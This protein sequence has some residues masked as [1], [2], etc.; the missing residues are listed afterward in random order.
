MEEV[1]YAYNYCIR[2]LSKRDYSVYKIKR[3]LNERKYDIDVIESVVEKLLEQNYLREDEFKR[4]KIKQHLYKG[5]SNSYIQNKLSSTEKLTCT[6]EEI[7][8]LRE[9]MG[10]TS[11]D[12]INGLIDKKLRGNKSP[13]SFE[14]KMKL[15]KKLMSF[16]ISKGHSY[17]QI[18]TPVEE[19]LSILN[20]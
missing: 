17:D 18:C 20:Q 4:Q 6:D 2:L 10:H 11:I 13:N 14:E 19:K 1:K 9:D 12:Q 8:R 16:L 5:Y 3:K 15:K 7:D